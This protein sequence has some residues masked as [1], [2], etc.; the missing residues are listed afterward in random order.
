MKIKDENKKKSKLL[1]QENEKVKLD[2]E[3]L[4]INKPAKSNRNERQLLILD[5]ENYSKSLLKLKK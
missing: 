5:N 2:F 1:E 3:I 4:R